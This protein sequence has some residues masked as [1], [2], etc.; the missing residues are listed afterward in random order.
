MRVFTTITWRHGCS[1]HLIAS[2]SLISAVEEIYMQWRVGDVVTRS[3]GSVPGITEA[4][5]LFNAMLN[6]IL[7][8]GIPTTTLT[9]TLTT[10]ISTTKIHGISYQSNEDKSA[11]HGFPGFGRYHRSGE[12]NGASWCC[13]THGNLAFLV[14]LTTQLSTLCSFVD[15]S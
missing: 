11:V 13:Q 7:R 5:Q 4:V 1:Y 10:A 14:L 2:N 8:H 12:C 3:L 6:T 9:L 15:L